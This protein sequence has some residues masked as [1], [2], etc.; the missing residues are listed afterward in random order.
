MTTFLVLPLYLW[1]LSPHDELLWAFVG[2]SFFILAT[3]RGNIAQ[4]IRREEP[5]ID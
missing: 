2:L 3:H 5:T 1:L 4:L